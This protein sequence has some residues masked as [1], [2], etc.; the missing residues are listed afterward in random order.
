LNTLQRRDNDMTVRSYLT[1]AVAQ[2]MAAVQLGTDD[3]PGWE[4]ETGVTNLANTL[5]LNGAERPRFILDCYVNATTES[6]DPSC[7]SLALYLAETR[8]E[9]HAALD[10]AWETELQDPTCPECEGSNLTEDQTRCFDCS[11]EETR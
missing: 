10:A 4:W 8:K 5:G 11:A 7:S 6:D 2:A 1:K 3:P 9:L